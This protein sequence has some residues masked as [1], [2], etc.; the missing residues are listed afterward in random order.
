M[1]H[2]I[3][4][5]VI[6]QIDKSNF[7]KLKKNVLFIFMNLSNQILNLIVLSFLFN[8]IRLNA[9]NVTPIQDDSV[10][11]YS[12]KEFVI[13]GQYKEQS[14]EKST[15]NIKVVSKDAIQKMG[16]QQLSDVLEKEMKVNISQDNILGSSMSLQ[17]I[18]GQNVKIL[19]DGIPLTGRLNGNIDLSQINLNQVQRIEI[20]EGPMSVSYGTD[21]LAGTI[22]IITQKRKNKN[23]T[24]NVGSYYE[25]IGR[26]HLNTASDSKIKNTSFKISGMRNFFDGWNESDANFNIVKKGYADSSRYAS[27]KP[28][29]QYSTS[30]DIAQD[31]DKWTIGLHSDYFFE[32]IMNR[33]YPRAPYNESAFDDQYLTHRFNNNLNFKSAL[34]PNYH[35]QGFIDYSYFERTKNTYLK[36][37]TTLEPTMT[38]NPGDQDTTKFKNWMSRVSIHSTKNQAINYEAGYDAQSEI[39]LGNRIANGKKE[40]FDFAVFGSAE[41]KPYYKLTIRPGLR[42]IYNTIYK[43]PLIP[44]I[45]MKYDLYQ[46]KNESTLLSLRFSYGRGF[47]APSLK[48]MYFYFVDIN[49]DIQGNPNLKEE[50]SHSFNSNLFYSRNLNQYTLTIDANSFYNYINNMITLSNVNATTFSYFNLHQ[51]VSKG[52]QLT[53]ELSSKRFSIMLS[54]GIIGRYNVLADSLKNTTKFAYSPEVK[55]TFRYLLEKQNTTFSIY[56]KY[57]GKLP[58]FVIDENKELITGVNSDY[59]LLDATISKPFLKKKIT[60]TFGGKNLLN[61]KNINGVLLGGAHAAGS[62]SVSIATGRSFFINLQFNANSER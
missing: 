7:A 35:I 26:Y 28:K 60:L 34:N 25:S 41:L 59:S 37:L 29:L 13:T 31:I 9:Q 62:N 56:Y 44:S 20:I 55:S 15:M 51:F 30:V 36:D 50:R 49:H 43:A 61:V 10:R 14:I 1:H 53:N 22:N 12:L 54:G 17:G 21:A 48:E 5:L 57:I 58:I 23:Y 16:A 8:V 32:K 42:F 4:I 40:Q 47:R 46:D 52:F 6:Y 27:W 3:S 2:F 11:H 24:F 18:S 45:H 39:A 19:I 33:G 38:N